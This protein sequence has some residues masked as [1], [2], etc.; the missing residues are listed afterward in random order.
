V[1]ALV[2]GSS[3]FIGSRLAAALVGQGAE[4]RALHRA[5]SRLDALDGLPVRHFIG[6]VLDV[7]GLRRAMAGCDVV[8][9]V[10][11]VASYWRATAD[12][13]YRVN[14]DGT[15]HVLAACRDAGVGR[16][17]YTSSVAAVG[18]PP[19]GT[20]ANEEHAFDAFSA[21]WPYSDS[22]RLAEDEVRRAVAAGQ[23]AV[24]VNPAVVMGAGDHYLISGSMIVESARRQIPFC[25]PGGLCL[26]DVDAVVQGHLRAAALGRPGER[27]ILGGENLTFCE[28]L[29][30]I[31]QVTGRRP[32]RLTI[33]PWTIAP[34]ANAVEAYN[35]VSGRTPLLNGVQVRLS[36]RHLYYDSS[37]AVRQ[38]AYPIMPFAAAAEKAYRWYGEHG[39]LN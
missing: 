22:K 38:L 15:R 11:A 1:K 26:A 8:F 2:T 18:I 10:A 12:E 25:P 7:D 24:I 27:Y 31:S 37:K 17:V 29:T 20:I 39:F 9:H 32:P 30:V 4:V 33:P 19:E 28:M 16:L 23:W 36:R 34:I 21:H 3:G 5:G 13:V 14:V 6:D 35:R